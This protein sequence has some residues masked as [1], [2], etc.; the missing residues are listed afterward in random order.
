MATVA[1]VSARQMISVNGRAL[2]A[3]VSGPKRELPGAEETIAL[4]NIFVKSRTHIIDR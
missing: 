2:L 3:I 1:K 4:C